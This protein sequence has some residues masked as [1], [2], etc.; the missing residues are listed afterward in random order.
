VSAPSGVEA[1]RA[2]ADAALYRGY[3]L[4][5]HVAGE[6]G[7]HGPFGVLT[8]PA[9]AGRGGHSSCRAE[10]LLEHEPGDGS[11]LVTDPDRR[12]DLGVLRVRIR[13]L[14]LVDRAVWVGAR[15]GVTPADAAGGPGGELCAW[16]EPA[17]CDQDALIPLADLLAGAGDVGAGDVGTRCGGAGGAGPDPA[18][19][20]IP[21]VSPA[22]RNV[23][24]AAVPIGPPGRGR[25]VRAWHRLDAQLSLTARWLPGP[26]RT[27]HLGAELR[28]TSRWSPA[29][30][31]LAAWGA[32][33]P[34]GLSGALDAPGGDAVRDEALRRSLI[35]A[36]L[37]FSAP[38]WRFLSLARPPWWAVTFAASCHN[39]RSWPVPVGGAGL[40]RDDT[41]LVAPVVLPDHPRPPYASA[42]AARAAGRSHGSAPVYAASSRPPV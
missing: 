32:A 8:P 15:D 23:Q 3:Q 7:R 1:A 13:F 39:E 26:F 30:G 34:A 4:H 11:G 25:L 18:R 21:V 31:E 16:W 10:C 27:V 2:V 37:V 12:A 6:H 5:P 14:R 9:Y 17:P 24:L 33:D 35:A 40:G 38:G 28:N 42:G 19:W 29:A 22:G 20:T 36:H 41:A